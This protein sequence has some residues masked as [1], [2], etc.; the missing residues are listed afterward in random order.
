MINE[1]KLIQELFSQAIYTD[2]SYGRGIQSGI[3][4]ALEIVQKQPKIGE[5]IPVSERLPEGENGSETG[6]LLFQTSSGTIE[7]GYFGKEGKIRKSYFRTYI[8]S[9]EGCSS[10]DVVAW[11]QMPEPY[12]EE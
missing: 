8:S 6:P 3:N 2:N 12:K 11:M 5:W 7:A 4:R 1:K 9:T 10:D